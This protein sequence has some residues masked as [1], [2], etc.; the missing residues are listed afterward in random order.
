MKLSIIT[1]NKNNAAGLEKTAQSVVTQ[2]FSDFEYI[3]IDG[4][5]DDGSIDVI[6]K[7]ADK[8]TYWVSKPD[9]GIYNAMNKGIKQAHGDFCLFL[10]SGDCL[11]EA[12]TLKNVFD[13]ITGLAEAGIYYSDVITTDGS[14]IIYPKDVTV[15]SLLRNGS[16]NHQNI[17]IRRSL[18]FCHGMYNERY[19]IISDYEFCLKEIWIYKTRFVHLKTMITLYDMSGISSTTDYN[20]ETSNMLYDMFIDLVDAMPVF[21]EFRNS[22]YYDIVTKYG[23]SK[24][25]N[26]FLKIYRF[27]IKKWR[28]LQKK[29]RK[30]G[31][32]RR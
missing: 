28:L 9:A 25:L 31:Y 4:G 7:Y 21:R 8:I 3:V 32:F 23:N 12:E 15:Y 10:N 18:F 17:L 22:I 27:F 24:P 2:T 19:K 30:M 29:L 13:E 11:I 5:S 26:I 14:K 1:V 6:R 16:I 20:H